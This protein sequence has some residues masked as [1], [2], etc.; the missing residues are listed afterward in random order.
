MTVR[1]VAFCLGISSTAFAAPALAQPASATCD[2]V[3]VSGTTEKAP[4]IDPALKP[5]EK[6]LQKAAG[7][8]NSFKQLSR[9]SVPLTANKP[10]TSSLKSGSTEL[11]LRSRKPAHVELTISIDDAGGKRL[12]NNSQVG[13][14]GG[15]WLMFAHEAGNTAHLVALTCK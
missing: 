14:D 1:T 2:V 11:M 7:G 4:S 13:V 10:K 3:E 6:R 8:A 9:Q 12:V 15:D 5:L